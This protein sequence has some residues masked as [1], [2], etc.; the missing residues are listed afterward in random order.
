MAPSPTQHLICNFVDYSHLQILEG[1]FFILLQ[2]LK[3]FRLIGLGV[4]DTHFKDVLKS[5]EDDT[6]SYV[7]SK[8]LGR[9]KPSL[10]VFAQKK[11]SELWTSC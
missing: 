1:A 10:F 5:V 6:L 8:I 3:Q 2:V 4:F 7:I 9:L 11:I